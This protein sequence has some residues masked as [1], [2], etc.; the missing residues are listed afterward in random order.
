M[1]SPWWVWFPGIE[2]RT[3]LLRAGGLSNQIV[4]IC[5]RNISLYIYGMAYSGNN[6]FVW[7]V[8]IVRCMYS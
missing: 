6:A 7:A 5:T 2:T 8:Y 3:F 1:Q 4:K